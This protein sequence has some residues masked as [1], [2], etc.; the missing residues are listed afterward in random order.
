MFGVALGISEAELDRV[1]NFDE[2][3]KY[4]HC[5]TYSNACKMAGPLVQSLLYPPNADRHVAGE[6]YDLMTALLVLISHVIINS[7][8]FTLFCIIGSLV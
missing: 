6:S 5:Q 3:V 7:F 2:R 8:Y 1:D 4:L